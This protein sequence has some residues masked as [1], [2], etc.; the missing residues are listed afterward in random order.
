VSAAGDVLSEKSRRRARK[1]AK[2]LLLASLD[3]AQRRD[4]K[5]KGHFHVWGSKGNVYRIGPADGAFNVRLAGVAKGSRMFFCLE[6]EDPDVPPE[7]VMLA[8]KLLIEHDEGE[9]LRQA[10]MAYIPK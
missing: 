9:F 10:N 3:A 7:D 4:L 2:K 6:T 1:R 5:R 8:Q